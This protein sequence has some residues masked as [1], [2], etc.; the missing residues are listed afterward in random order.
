MHKKFLRTFLASS[1][2]VYTSIVC[3]TMSG[4]QCYGMHMEWDDENE[5]NNAKTL[6]QREPYAWTVLD[7]RTYYFLTEEIK[8]ITKMSPTEIYIEVLRPMQQ[9][10]YSFSTQAPKNWTYIT[11]KLPKANGLTHS[12]LQECIRQAYSKSYYEYLKNHGL[13]DK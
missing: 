6:L 10:L 2:A 11:D 9:N 13:V 1:V 12:K 5:R 3:V 8:S 7:K 4:T